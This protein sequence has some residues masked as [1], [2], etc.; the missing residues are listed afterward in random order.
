VIIGPLGL[1]SGLLTVNSNQL[2]DAINA[3]NSGGGY[4]V[5]ASSS[6]TG[7]YGLSTSGQGAGVWGVNSTSTGV[8]VVGLGYGDSGVFGQSSQGNGV[9]GQGPENGVKSYG[10]M[11][12]TGDLTIEGSAQ[13]THDVSAESAHIQAQLVCRD[14]FVSGNKSFLIDHPLDPANK[15]L[16]HYCAEGPEPMNIYSGNVTLDTAG[17]AIIELPGYYSEINRDARYQLT[18]I[19]AAMPLLH[20]AR[21]VENNRFAIA[22]G[23]PGAEVSWRIEA[24]RNDRW[25]RAHGAPVEIDKTEKERG[26]YYQPELYDRPVEDGINYR[27][28]PAQHSQPVGRASRP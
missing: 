27:S 20:V 1:D 26:K 12:A 7:V 16:K 19:G 2:L 14:L 25:V 6:G 4:A 10:N 8:G 15:A 28:K 22:G 24:V 21:K 3:E 18:P 9:V 17:D 23:A 11:T 13:I 5:R